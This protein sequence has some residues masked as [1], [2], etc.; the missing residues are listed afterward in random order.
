MPVILPNRLLRRASDEDLAEHYDRVS[1]GHTAKDERAKAQVLHELDRRDQVARARR[2]AGDRRAEQRGD[3]ELTV[4]SEFVRAEEVTRGNLLNKKGVAA[5]INP[6][7]L[8][9]GREAEAR[10]YASDELL[11]YWQ[12]HHR[13]TAASFRGQDT[14]VQPKATEPKRRTWTRSGSGAGYVRR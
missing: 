9:T 13:P 5:G 6:R 12:T 10:R 2:A 8:F 1:H 11:E 14:R 3:R 7:R 4:E